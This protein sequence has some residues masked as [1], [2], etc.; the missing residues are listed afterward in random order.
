MEEILTVLWG[1]GVHCNHGSSSRQAGQDTTQNDQILFKD[2][3]RLSVLDP[4][5]SIVF[6]LHFLFWYS[7]I[8]LS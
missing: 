4:A 2:G 1:F 5:L 7:M 6:E 3:W 8:I